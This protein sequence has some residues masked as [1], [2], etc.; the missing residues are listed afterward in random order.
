[1]KTA[2]LIGADLDWWTAQAVGVDV[3]RPPSGRV[4]YWGGK[5]TPSE[6]WS[7]GGPLIADYKICVYYGYF[8]YEA[9]LGGGHGKECY[10]WRA[11]V[12]PDVWHE[13]DV[14]T[15]DL[16]YEQFGHTPLVA[17]CR[18]IVASKFGEV[19]D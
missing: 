5:Y 15:L 11:G 13:Y 10:A 16:T 2:E 3:A 7:Q 9:K 12:D 4:W 17:V 6:D 8:P 18:S 19:V 14:P 1:M